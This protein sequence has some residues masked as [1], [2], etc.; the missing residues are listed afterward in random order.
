MGLVDLRDV[1]F[2]YPEGSLAL[3]GVDM[4]VRA[5]S[6]TALLASNGSGKTTLIK[7]I[8]GLLTP[9][10]GGIT[11]DGEP[12]STLSPKRL[13]G[14]I[15]VVFQNPDDQLFAPTAADDVAFGP[16][17]MGLDEKT[18]G[19][20]V[21]ES[22]D[23]V[24]MLHAAGRSVHHLSFGEK[25]KVAL[26]GVLAMRPR[27]LLLDEPTASLDPAGEA[28]MMRL[29]GNLNRLHGVTVV[30]ATHSVD[31]LPLFADEIYIFK[32]G[33]VLQRGSAR[34]ILSDHA[35]MHGAGLRLPYIS[36]LL[37]EMKTGDGLP[38]NGLPLTIGEARKRFL[39][40]I[41]DEVFSRPGGDEQN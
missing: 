17:N 28:D 27:L 7:L 16:R 38:I 1:S 22:L 29:I 23:A 5:G 2:R 6:F 15:G 41:P 30:M 31:L 26:A 13:Y 8:A 25:K 24:G 12:L 4:E 32:N 39:E 18:V 36:S 37:H 20:R 21:N 11:L 35:V 33:R 19:E 9:V 10:S 3:D 34:E 40:L 14:A